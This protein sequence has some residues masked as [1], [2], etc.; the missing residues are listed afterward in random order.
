MQSEPFYCNERLSMHSLCP[1]SYTR[2]MGLVQYAKFQNA[3]PVSTCG[4]C[5]P[6]DYIQRTPLCSAVRVVHEASRQ[7]A[8]HHGTVS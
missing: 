3:C 5:N 8:A 4:L 7:E 2:L 6:N 1:D